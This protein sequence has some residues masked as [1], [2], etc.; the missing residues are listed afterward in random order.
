MKS[1]VGMLDPPKKLSQDVAAWTVPFEN[2]E[3]L[4]TPE[5]FA[6]EPFGFLSISRCGV[7]F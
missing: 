4:E 3:F 5:T 2:F 6:W 1:P 7:F